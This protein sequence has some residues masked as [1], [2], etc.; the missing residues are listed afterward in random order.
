MDDPTPPAVPSPDAP[1]D[2]RE[3][4]FVLQVVQPGL[5]GL[6]DGSVSTLAPLFAAAFAT[7]L[8][9]SYSNVVGLDLHT[10]YQLLKGAGAA[11]LATNR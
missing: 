5:A 8:N 2:D 1:T 3:R 4:R 11:P 10:V 9:G 6:M 7:R